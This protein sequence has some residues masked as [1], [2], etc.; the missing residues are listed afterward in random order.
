MANAT[1]NER[2]E[3][4]ADY[5]AAGR[6]H[7]EPHPA[8]GIP[9]GNGTAS[10]PE[11]R[12]RPDA[13]HSGSHGHE[14]RRPEGRVASSRGWVGGSDGSTE[15]DTAGQ[16]KGSVGMGARGGHRNGADPRSDAHRKIHSATQMTPN[17]V[18]A[19]R[20]CVGLLAGFAMIWVALHYFH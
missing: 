11:A 15:I 16:F 18:W 19:V 6:H 4:I 20:C 5:L 17:W 10:Q 2:L 14:N 3:W 13:S 8:S 1:A 7:A 9:T 12:R